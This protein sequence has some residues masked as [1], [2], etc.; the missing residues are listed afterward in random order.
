MVAAKAD[1]L[2]VD[3]VSTGTLF[4]SE[5]PASGNFSGKWGEFGVV[6]AQIRLLGACRHWHFSSIPWVAGQGSSDGV[7]GNLPG[8]HAVPGLGFGKNSNYPQGCFEL[9][10]ITHHLDWMGCKKEVIELSQDTELK[11][12]KSMAREMLSIWQGSLPKGGESLR[13]RRLY[14]SQGCIS[15]LRFRNE[16]LSINNQQRRKT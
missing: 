8:F 13:T 3:A 11:D 12:I 5:Y 15:S 2:A 1:L 4:G 14:P 7:A 6:S 9:K 10:G 16:R